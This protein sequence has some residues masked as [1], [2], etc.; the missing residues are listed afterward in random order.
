MQKFFIFEVM[1]AHKMTLYEIFHDFS[2]FTSFNIYI[3]IYSQRIAI[4]GYIF[5]LVIFQEESNRVISFE[6]KVS[7]IEIFFRI[8]VYIHDIYIYK[9]YIP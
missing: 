8:G 7:N 6:K 4:K 5:S 3:Y 9:I 2:L 1:V